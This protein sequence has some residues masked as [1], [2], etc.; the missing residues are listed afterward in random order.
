MI[1]K[2]IMDNLKQQNVDSICH[3]IPMIKAFVNKIEI[4]S[5]FYLLN[6]IKVSC[7]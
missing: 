6:K 3:Q 1:N 4:I 5:L 7:S 2:I